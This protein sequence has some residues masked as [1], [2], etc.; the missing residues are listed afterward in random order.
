MSIPRFHPYIV[1]NYTKKFRQLWSRNPH[2]NH[3]RHLA[4][5]PTTLPA[6][7]QTER[8]PLLR[9]AGTVAVQRE[10]EAPVHP[11]P[12][13]LYSYEP[14]EMA[15]PSQEPASE[16]FFNWDTGNFIIDLDNFLTHRNPTWTTG[17]RSPSGIVYE[18]RMPDFLSFGLVG[19]QGVDTWYTWPAHPRWAAASIGKNL[20][21]TAKGYFNFVLGDNV[22]NYGVTDP[23]S[24][25][26]KQTFSA[27]FKGLPCWVILGNHDYNMSSASRWSY[28]RPDGT[29]VKTYRALC[30]VYYSYIKNEGTD[31]DF[32]S[33]EGSMWNM[34]YPYYT[35]VSKKYNVV[36]ICIDSNTLIFNLEQQ[37]WVVETYEK[38]ETMKLPRDSTSFHAKPPSFI[39]VSHHPFNYYSERAHKRCE[40]KQ[41]V[42]PGMLT[43]PKL[44]LNRNI[45]TTKT[46]PELEKRVDVTLP[47]N[48]NTIG[49]ILREFVEVN[50]LYFK[51]SFN[52]HDHLLAHE[53]IT[54]N[55][56]VGDVIT[57]KIVHQF[58]SGGGGAKPNRV[59]RDFV[60]NTPDREVHSKWGYMRVSLN[61]ETMY[62]DVFVRNDVNKLY[63]PMPR[64]TIELNTDAAAAPPPPARAESSEPD[65]DHDEYAQPPR[66]REGRGPYEVSADEV[67]QPGGETEA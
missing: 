62:V 8:T 23:R 44:M 53:K 17:R 61:A 20:S 3:E 32:V 34:P 2:V 40:W 49:K 48:L 31:Y 9:G 6:P 47:G 60:I 5:E 37:N 15:P 25:L 57:Q 24:D 58:I 41:Y 26:F 54:L 56:K 12:Y 38:F 18:T 33:S 1:L 35:L 13:A 28:L 42:Q 36:F 43:E 50:N 10:R 45:N 30:Q 66:S 14:I 22:Y 29:S 21:N 4:I 64:V 16:D 19:C 46:I 39:L 65:S 51:A 67:Y 7:E 27:I 11:N 59:L 63:E 52:A 55:Y